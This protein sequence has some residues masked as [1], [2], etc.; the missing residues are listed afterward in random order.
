VSGSNQ[1]GGGGASAYTVVGSF[2]G[3][4][5]GGA[6]Q[7]RFCEIPSR[8]NTQLIRILKS[9]LA[10]PFSQCVAGDVTCEE[11]ANQARPLLN[12]VEI[13]DEHLLLGVELW[14]EDERG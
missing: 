6:W 8:A 4:A 12:G 7:R 3:G 14:S 2:F 5:A 11:I 10:E 9:E 13:S 1:K